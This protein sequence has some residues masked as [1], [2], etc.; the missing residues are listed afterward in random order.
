MTKMRFRPML[1]ILLFNILGFGLLF[2]YDGANKVSYF[3][4][5]A[6]I[7]AIN[8]IMYML[9]YHLEYGDL[10]L[11]LT[12]SMLVSIGIIMLT[13][14]DIAKNLISEK[15]VSS[16]SSK[17]V[18]WFIIGIFTYFLTIVIFKKIKI[19]NKL[20]RIYIPLC[21]LLVLLTLILGTTINGSKN[22]IVLGS[23]SIQPSEIIKILFCM[24]IATYFC[25][26]PSFNSKKRDT[27]KRF[28]N[29]PIDEIY[30]CVFVYSIMGSL[31]LFQKEWGSALLLFLIYFVMCFIYK[32]SN[33]LKIIN[34][35]MIALAIF[36]GINFLASHIG[37]RVNAW[38]N[39]WQDAQGS[40]YQIVQSLIAITQGGYFGSGLANGFPLNVPFCETDFIFASICEEMGIFMGFSVILLYFIFTY[41]G[42]KITVR[43]ENEYLK[44]LC[45]SLVIQ[46]AFQTFI[47]IGGV[48]KLLPLTGIT[49]PFVSYG[50]S[51]MLSSFILLGIITAISLE[52]ERKV[53]K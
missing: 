48:V 14:I 5:C 44:A 29:I 1:Y 10:Y 34:V 16:Y 2:L 11:F 36:V 42:V 53:S 51:S 12:S 38:K 24:A 9:L 7:C 22:W 35:C 45:L 47:I 15:V 50:G 17:Q 18:L 49:L 41:R 37:V 8:I 33:L 28:L 26:M 46:M 31:A 52:K 3:Y 43:I 23:V 21:F 19:W 6:S 39:P 40:G 20:R 32:T 13:R 30:L 4:T 27:R 25:N